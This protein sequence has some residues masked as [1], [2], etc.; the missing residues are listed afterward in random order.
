MYVCVFVFI[1]LSVCMLCVYVSYHTTVQA[2]DDEL[3]QG[4][5]DEDSADVQA[6]TPGP[7]E[8]IQAELQQGAAGRP[9]G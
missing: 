6:D 9:S 3:V 8:R 5:R 7:L 2:W 1:T 4:Y